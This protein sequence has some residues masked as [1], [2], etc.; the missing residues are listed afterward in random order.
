MATYVTLLKWTDSGVRNV[1]E[2]PKRLDDARQAFEAAGGRIDRFYMVFGDYDV[3]C[4]IECPDDET[5]ARTILSI[6]SRGAV[7]TTTLKALSESQYRQIISSL[8]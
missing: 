4:I 1:R 2:S 7:A 3:V 5:Y 6:A 8:P